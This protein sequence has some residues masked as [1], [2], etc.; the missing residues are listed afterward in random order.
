MF[1]GPVRF[2]CAI[3]AAD[4]RN[5]LTTLERLGGDPRGNRTSSMGPSRSPAAFQPRDRGVA[6]RSLGEGGFESHS[7][8]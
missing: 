8:G 7:I 1:E 2:L 3:A 6:H 5:S 4:R